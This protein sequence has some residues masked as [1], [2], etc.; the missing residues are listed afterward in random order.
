VALPAPPASVEPGEQDSIA[1]PG[2]RPEREWTVSDSEALKKV[3]VLLVEDDAD[4]REMLVLVL[5]RSGAMVTAAAS[6][7]EAREA[8]RRATPDLLVCDIGLPGED[9]LELMRKIRTVEVDKGGRI[10]ALALTAYSDWTHR[11]MALAAGFDQQISKPVVPGEL[12]AQVALL[13][14]PRGGPD[15]P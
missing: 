11:E 13:A 7:G 5:E 4:N 2:S 14:G 15:E 6:A 12:V 1:P 3:R 9:G 8:M 10:P